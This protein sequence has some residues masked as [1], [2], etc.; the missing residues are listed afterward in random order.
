MNDHMELSLS[1]LAQKI[2]RD[3]VVDGFEVQI[4]KERLYENGVIDR[5]EADFFFKVNDTVTGIKNDAFWRALFV[6]ALT[7]HFLNDS[8]SPGS[9]DDVEGQY[10][11]RKICKDGKIDDLELGLLVNIISKANTCPMELIDFAME[12]MTARILRDGFIDDYEVEM[13]QKLSYGIGGNKDESIDRT[14]AN[15]LFDLNDKASGMPNSPAWKDLFVEA[16]G[17]H[18]L[19][20]QFSPGVVNEETVNWLIERISA[21]GNID[22]NE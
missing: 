6:D 11:L 12:A 13:V 5:D 17:K 7:D 9:I 20:D 16:V 22:E 15:F 14:K 8:K 18:V 2:T 19:E 21:D 3:G 1:A 4:I 10:I